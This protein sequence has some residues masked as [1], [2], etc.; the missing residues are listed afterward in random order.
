MHQVEVGTKNTDTFFCHSFNLQVRVGSI[1]F[2][3]LRH[4]CIDFQKLCAHH[5]EEILRIPKHP[6]LAKFGRVLAK[7]TAK[8]KVVSKIQYQTNFW[9]FLFSW[10]CHNLAQNHPNFACWGCFGILRTR[11]GWPP[12]TYFSTHGNQLPS[13]SGV[14]GVKD[15]LCSA[16]LHGSF[17]GRI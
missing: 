17:D 1:N 12:K 13:M 15:F 2:N 8:N 16:H 4:F 6:Q 9:I 7:K 5:E 3:F 14:H 10:D 11:P